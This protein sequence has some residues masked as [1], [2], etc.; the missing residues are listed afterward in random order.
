MF[1]SLNYAFSSPN[2]TKLS[3]IIFYNTECNTTK[4]GLQNEDDEATTQLKKEYKKVLHYIYEDAEWFICDD[5][6]YGNKGWKEEI[7][8]NNFNKKEC[9]I[10]FADSIQRDL[11]SAAKKNKSTIVERNMGYDDAHFKYEKDMEDGTHII[12]FN[13]YDDD[14]DE[15]VYVFFW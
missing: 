10:F 8:Y 9:I 7:I 13:K 11:N 12:V 14:S 5:N 6:K 4:F 2:E 1:I 3:N 15:E